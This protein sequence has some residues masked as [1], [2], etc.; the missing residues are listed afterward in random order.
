[1]GFLHRR[2]ASGNAANLLTVAGPVSDRLR[3]TEASIQPHPQAV[4][5]V[6]QEVDDKHEKYS[7]Y[8]NHNRLARLLPVEHLVDAGLVVPVEKER[9]TECEVGGRETGRA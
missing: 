4:H 9:E 3:E 5:A 1:M 2:E 7:Q 8:A 6:A